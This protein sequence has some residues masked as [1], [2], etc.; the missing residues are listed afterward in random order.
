MI[1]NILSRLEKVK[2][3]GNGKFKTLCPAH[4][5]SSPSLAVSDMGDKVLI[6]CWAGCQVDDIL[7]AIGLEW[8]DLFLDSISSESKVHYR[9]KNEIKEFKHALTILQIADKTR[10]LGERLT[11]NDLDLEKKAWITVNK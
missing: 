10:D 4:N 1:E 11:P 8:S 7:T 3:V 5:D 2:S 6:K 9:Q